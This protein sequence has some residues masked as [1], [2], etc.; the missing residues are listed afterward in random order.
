MA[1]DLHDLSIAELSGL[2]AARKLSPVE[3]VE[4]LIQRVEQYDGA[5]ARL[6]HAHVRPGPAAGP[7]GRGRDRGGHAPRA[8]CTGSPS[9][10]RTSTTRGASSPPAH[11]RVFIDR[12]P[13][14]DATDDDA[15]STTPAPC[16]SASWPPTRWRTPGRRSIC[17]GRPRATRGTSP[18]SPAAPPS[19]SGAAVAAGLVPVALGSDT[20]GS[21]RGPASLC[22]V[23]GL[24][25]T[26][27]LVSRAGVITNSYTFDHCGPLARTV[28]DCALVLEALAGYDPKDAGSLRRPIPRYREALGQDLRGLRIGVLRHHWEEDIPASED[29][30]TA[31]DAALDVLRRLGAELEE[32]RVRPLGQLLRRQD[33]HRRERDLQRAPAEPDRP[34]RATS[35]PT[36]APARC[37]SVLFTANDYVQ[38]TREHRRMMVE[39]EPLYAQIRRL[40]HRRHGRGA[41]ARRLPQR[42]VLAEAEPA[43]RVERHGPAR[44]RAA[45]RLRQERPAARHAD[46]RPALRRGRRSCA[47]A[48][49]TSRPPSGTRGVPRSCPARRRP[50]SRPR[51]CSRAPPIRPTPRRAISASKAA[52]RAGLP[53]DDL[54]LAQLL[55]GAPY[56]L[57][58]VRA[59]PPRPRPAPRARERLQLSHDQDE[60]DAMS[61]RPNRVK[62]QLAAGKVATILSGTND[63]DLIDQLGTARRRRHL[64]RGRARRRR[65]R[66]PRQ[67]DPRLRPLGHDLGGARDGQ[68]L[69]HDLPHPRPRRPGHRGAARQHARGGRGGGRGGQVRAARQ[70]RHVHEPPGLRRGRLPQDRQRPEPAHRP[71]RGHRGRAQPRRDPQGRP[72][73]RLLRGAQRP[74]DL[75][76][77]DRQHGPPGG[78]ADD[79]RGDR[80]DRRSPAA[81]RAR[82][83]TPPTWSATRGSACAAS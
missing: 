22:G 40:R 23:V 58:M 2:I 3:L 54:M 25:P 48:T 74:R 75:D 59:P 37:P 52:R 80:E 17:P 32:C 15:G 14:E 65:L 73:R 29:V 18:T 11:S 45:Q 10:S 47:S 35:A 56:A 34:A 13:A 68:R 60:G 36:F 6:H 67:P 28:E 8:R 53:L 4:A 31:M 49:P 24:M 5:D 21:I 26:F 43:H 50:P 51:P 66:R 9:R 81:P 33:H 19:G 72:H 38:A 44:A 76:G 42:L 82:W 30:R 20:G 46:P 55:E 7:A 27:G 69:R 41:A 62:Q 77:P 79:R 12:I 83:S 78:P 1:T 71:D 63:P 70:A 16:C 57:G 61:I 39:M 64:A